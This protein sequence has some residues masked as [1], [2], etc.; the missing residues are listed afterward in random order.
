VSENSVDGDALSTV[1]FLM[2]L[3]KGLEIINSMENIEAV[4]VTK[5]H[6]LIVTQGLKDIFEFDENNYKDIY[7]V[8]YR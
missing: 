3:E 8:V 5:D 1:V 4:F 7:E 6:K 2:G